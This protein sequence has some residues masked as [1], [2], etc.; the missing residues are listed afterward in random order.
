MRKSLFSIGLLALMAATALAQ[1][2]PTAGE[3][4]FKEKCTACHTM[5]GGR[6]VGPD[7][8][9]VT[10]KR[11]AEWIAS[12]VRSSA[13]FIAS[14]DAEA[15]AIYQE[16]S[17]ISMPDHNFNDGEMANLLAYMGQ[18]GGTGASTASTEPAPSLLEGVGEAEELLG[19]QLFDG[20]VKFANGGPSCMS[21]HTTATSYQ[22]NDKSY[23]RNV[24][25]SYV[26]LGE[27]GL[28]AV[29]QTPSFPVMAKAFHERKIEDSELIP[30]MAY[31]R[32]LSANSETAQAS[33]GLLTY[34]FI[35]ALLLIGLFAMLWAKRKTAPVSDSIY[36]RQIKSIN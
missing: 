3:T 20:R 34:G 6:L 27:A 26:N 32:K 11:S 23:A 33:S 13:T 36:K 14:G 19:E 2:D 1:G 4:L 25:M 31:L 16:Y 10:E 28:K 7:L 15:N 30:L 8:Q 21:C 18:F 29:I 17:G 35:G 12:F 5:G 24:N 9:G 22:F